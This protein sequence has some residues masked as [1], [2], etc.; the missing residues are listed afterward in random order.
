MRNKSPLFYQ[1]VETEYLS[2]FPMFESQRFF[3]KIILP[4]FRE[5][6]NKKATFSARFVKLLSYLRSKA[7]FKK[8]KQTFVVI[9]S[10]YNLALIYFEKN[11]FCW[12]LL[13]TEWIL[14][15]KFWMPLFRI[16]GTYKCTWYIAV[17]RNSILICHT[18]AWVFSSK[19]A[20]Y[21][22]NTFS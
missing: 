10:L 1:K 5:C 21:F 13:L 8:M 2:K 6:Q 17:I 3:L 22:Q 16:L 19:F 14:I 9:S 20:A 11:K 12:D 18:S 7:F 15:Q 4:N